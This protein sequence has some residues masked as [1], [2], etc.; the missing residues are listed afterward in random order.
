MKR[1]VVTGAS[2]FIGGRIVEAALDRGIEVIALSRN[3]SAVLQKSKPGLQVKRWVVGEP[4]PEIGD[5]SAL[6]HL[7]AYMP[8]D[9]NDPGQAALCF[10]TNVVGAI[11]LAI[12]AADQGIERFLYFGSG[13]IY[14]PDQAA[15]TEQ[16]IVY[17]LERATYYLASKLAG[18]LCVQAAA[19]R[20]G[21]Q[22]VVLRLASIYGPGMHVGGMIPNFIGRLSVGQTV[23]LMDGGAYHVDL[24]YIDDVLDV[25][26][27]AIESQETGVFNVGSGV[28]STALQA[29]TIVADTLGASRDL[30]V[31]EG[32]VKTS[33]F[34][35][36]D[37]SK[38]TQA[39]DFKPT[40][41]EDGIPRWLKG[42]QESN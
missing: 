1:L 29:A 10:E 36:L 39:F 9:F 16:S 4:L 11:D 38:A 2:G 42:S 37:I 7:A 35:P 27:K 24:A 22:T 33:G 25:T 3:P 21:L 34:T 30:I 15:A 19:K 23:T 8:S 41:L 17:P 28:A 6:C 20:K 18:E 26:F 40:R 32:D 14:S 13:Q 31:V 12:Q 5:A